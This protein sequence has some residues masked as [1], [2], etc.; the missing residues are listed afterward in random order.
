MRGS[1]AS[2]R[3]CC[4]TRRDDHDGGRHARSRVLQ[5]AGRHGGPAVHYFVN[6]GGGAYLSFGTALQWPSQPP[7]SDWAHYPTYDAVSA[8]IEGLSPWWKRP[9]WWWTRQFGGWPITAEWLSAMFDYNVEP[10]FQSFIEVK[11]EPSAHRVRLI[12]HGVN[13]PLTLGDVATSASFRPAGATDQ[14]PLEWIVP[15]R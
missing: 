15:M 4:G 1:R 8:K 6:G 11:V 10:F 12:P 5:R 14:T 9:A 13:G 7:T 2:S 3:R